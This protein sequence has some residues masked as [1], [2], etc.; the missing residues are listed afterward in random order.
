MQP[1]AMKVESRAIDD[2]R[3]GLEPFK[4]RLSPSDLLWAFSLMGLLL[5]TYFLL[6]YFAISSRNHSEAGWV[7]ATLFVILASV[8]IVVAT[9]TVFLRD[10]VFWMS[11]VIS[12]AL[13]LLAV[14]AWSQRVQGFRNG[15]G[16]IAVLLGP[17]LFF[18]VYR[19][20]R[21]LQP[22]FYDEQY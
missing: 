14:H 11:L 19:S 2:G 16:K 17:V 4:Y 5:L 22:R 8:L 20:V 7:D 18:A 15:A 12:A 1:Q 9:R 13:H 21:L 6:P 3:V 10:P